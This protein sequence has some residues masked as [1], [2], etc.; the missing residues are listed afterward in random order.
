LIP[1]YSSIKIKLVAVKYT[2][3]GKAFPLQ[4]WSGPD[5]SR[6]LGFLDFMT[7]AQGG[8]RFSALRTGR[9]YPQEIHLIFISVR[10]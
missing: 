9:L 7:T 5:S 4:A 2:K 3:K 8:G 6:N 10:G 1:L